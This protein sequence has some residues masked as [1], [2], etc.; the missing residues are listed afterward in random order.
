MGNSSSQ[1]RR[2][3]AAVETS[4]QAAPA[5]GSS[6]TLAAIT[7]TSA[8]RAR[9]ARASASPMR[10]EELLPTNLTLSIG[11]RV[12][13][14]VTST[15]SP[16]HALAPGRVSS[17]VGAPAEDSAS[18]SSHAVR[19]RAGSARRPTPC[20]PCEAS[21]PLS[22]STIHAPRSRSVLRFACVARCSYMRLFIAG[23]I[24]SGQSA[25]SAQLLSRLSARPAASLAIVFAE[26]GAIK[27]TSARATSSRWLSG[28]CSGS[29]CPGNAP[30]AGSRSNSLTSTGAPVSA[31][32]DA[33]PTNR[34]L[35]GVCTTLTACPA[36]VARRTSSS[37]LYA[38]MPP[39]TPS[40][41]RDMA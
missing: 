5:G 29:G 32:N 11:S 6:A 19:I 18:A 22:G 37:A 24:T 7:V 3:S 15:L 4:R 2:S 25:A 36:P 41:I 10:P 14:A 23:A 34:L 27:Y 26:A 20:S 39:L 30:R 21:R 16:R 38:A 28:A 1:A 8:P 40:R 9:A 31:S 12:P 35:A 33:A 17:W 13:P